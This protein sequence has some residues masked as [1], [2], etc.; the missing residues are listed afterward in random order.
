MRQM[1][2]ANQKLFEATIAKLQEIRESFGKRITSIEVKVADMEKTVDGKLV[3]MEE[4]INNL[5][6]RRPEPV[7]VYLKVQPG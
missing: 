1:H 5:H 4:K 2:A 7:L 6:S 3:M